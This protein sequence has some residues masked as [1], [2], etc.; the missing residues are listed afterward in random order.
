MLSRNE[1]STGI[2]AQN[3]LNS[4]KAAIINRK[5]VQIATIIGSDVTD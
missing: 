5:K 1:N 4:T 3:T 2:A